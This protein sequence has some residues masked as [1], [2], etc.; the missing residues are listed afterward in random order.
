MHHKIK[1]IITDHGIK[2]FS[3]ICLLS[4]IIYG[5]NIIHH[6]KHYYDDKREEIQHSID[7]IDEWCNNH[8]YR[9]DPE[10]REICQFHYKNAKQ[11]AFW[12]ALF[13]VAQDLRPCAI[14]YSHS[15]SMKADDHRHEN[16]DCSYLTYFFIIIVLI[17]FCYLFLK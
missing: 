11:S 3:T 16:Y 15:H 4:S 5:I 8:K 2:I 6:F 12:E 13:H 7:H 1:K 17:I 14:M 9:E 10:H